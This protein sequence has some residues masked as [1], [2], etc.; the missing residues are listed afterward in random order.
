VGHLD[1][2]EGALA[3]FLKVSL[4]ASAWPR[5]ILPAHV[6]HSNVRRA[7]SVGQHE[8]EV[9][10][11]PLRDC[12]QSWEVGKSCLGRGVLRAAANLFKFGWTDRHR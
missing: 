12:D 1:S 7:A 10:A 11:A 2:L 8:N 5:I 9:S 4:G 6:R 3:G